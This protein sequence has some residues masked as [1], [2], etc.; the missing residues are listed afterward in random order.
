MSAN[1]GLRLVCADILDGLAPSLLGSSWDLEAWRRKVYGADML[2]WAERF[3]YGDPVPAGE[4]QA[5]L[6]ELESERDD[7]GQLADDTEAEN[8]RLKRQIDELK[9]TVQFYRETNG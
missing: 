4:H 7:Y 9:A 3:Q 8:K 5:A 2:R 1:D 6:D